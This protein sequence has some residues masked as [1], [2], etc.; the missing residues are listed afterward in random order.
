MPTANDFAS[1][2][3]QRKEKLKRVR[4]RARVQFLSGTPG[5]QISAAISKGLDELL[6]ELIEEIGPQFATLEE[7]ASQ[8]AIIAIGGTGRGDPAP[9][10]D[11]DLLF[12]HNRI[13]ASDF[14]KFTTNFVQNLWD[15]RW[16]LGHSC[17]DIATCI[18]LA[19]SDP[20]IA[21]PLIEARFLWGNQKLFDQLTRKF[22]RTV[23]DARQRQFINDCLNARYENWDDNQAPKQELQPDIKS[24]AGGLRDLHLIRWIAFARYGIRDIDLLRLQGVMTKEDAGKLKKAWEFLTKVRIDLHLHAGREQDRLTREEQ[25]RI[26]ESR[27]FQGTDKQRGVEQFMQEYFNH[28][29]AIA[30]ISR[31]FAAVERPRGLQHV[32]KS[33][34]MSHRADNFL[35]V[36]S[37]EIDVARRNLSRVCKS[38]E[39]ILQLYK[40][41]ALYGVPISPRVADT[42]KERVPELQKEEMSPVAARIFLDILQR[43]EPLGYIIRSMFNT[44]VLDLVIPNVSHIR[45]LLQFNQYHHFT[46]DEHTLRAIEVVTG[47]AKDDGPI[48]TA[49]R[50][51][52]QKEVLHLALLLHDIAKGMG[53]D[54]SELGHDIA[55]QIGH[56]LAMP[57]HQI[58][59]AALLVLKHLV[60]A[61]IALR[62]DITDKKLLIDF[63]RD[64]GSPDTLRML[65]AL[66]AADITAVGP[67]TWTDWKSNLLTELFDR[68]MVILSGKRYSFH[69]ETRLKEIK[70]QVFELL[71]LKSQ[72]EYEYQWVENR[73]KGFSAYYL[74]CTSPKQIAKDLAVIDRL[75]ETSIEVVGDWDPE[76][77]TTEYRVI[78]RNADAVPGCFHKM[79]GVL[80][81]KRLEIIAADINTTKDGVIVDAY[82]VTDDD[83]AGEPPP[84]RMEEIAKT[85]R[86]VLSQKETVESLFQRNSR[87]GE[88][89]EEPEF[90]ELPT[91]VRIDNE[92]SDTRTIIDIFAYDRKGLLYVVA[93][94]LH[95]LNLS[96]DMAKIDTHFD[97]VNDVIYVQEA[98]R[99]KV[100]SSERLSDIQRT[101]EQTLHEFFETEHMEFTR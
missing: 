6:L 40:T 46:V 61:D 94:T 43:V 70:Q 47:F 79:C 31:H 22:K 77:Q 7:L 44:G 67:G 56:R 23:V 69:E 66:T 52:R 13:G 68:C 87:Y 41:A 18:S 25:L 98:D 48:G 39:S 11:L 10:S 26:S 64:V 101:L 38:L 51:I 65:Y 76:T 28:A 74:T 62:R 95:E 86:S 100:Q 55:L 57:L 45:N 21:T 24:S 37:D 35:I 92:S 90:S 93:K 97:Q 80:S 14:Q 99:T 82:Q 27:G 78:T 15:F 81:A 9:Y 96:V 32:A 4:D 71:N 50:A 53:G 84:F 19:K 85:L 58:E 42:I 63:S 83:F 33:L 29:S 17:R 60:M 1:V 5:I 73:L 30:E 72:Q 54:H 2:I 89:N 36:T 88:K 8:G 75:D 59:Q 16:E 12:L 20:Q 49:Y 3:E 34:L 91:R